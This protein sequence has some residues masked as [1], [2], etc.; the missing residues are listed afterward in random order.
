MDI[1]NLKTRKTILD[2]LHILVIIFSLL[3]IV[4]LSYDTFHDIPFLQ[5]SSY[6]H[7]QLVV[8]MIFLLDF[9]VELAL[10]LNKWKYFRDHLFFLL[11]SIP[12][13]NIIAYFKIDF[14]PDGLYY[15][16]FIPLI[17]AAFALAIVVGYIS[18]NKVSSLF[19]SYLAILLSVVYFSSLIFFEREFP[20][21]P[22]VTNYS[23]ALWW[24]AMNVTTLGC[25]IEP[26][27]QTGKILCVV[28]GG[29]GMMMFPLFTIYIT[30]LVQQQNLRDKISHLNVEGVDDKH[31]ENKII[32]PNPNS[33]SDSESK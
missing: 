13:L 28:L 26:V 22:S 9:F 30:N 18:K 15:I 14:S 24:A 2:V 6:M 1:K 4:Y 11:I 5:N 19:A 32:D 27:T 33:Q 8:C 21:N 29:C 10:A 23:D 16:R 12:Y 17:R 25:P 3:L 31:K 20:L 7:F